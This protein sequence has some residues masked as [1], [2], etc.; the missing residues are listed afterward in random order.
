[1]IKIMLAAAAFG[2]IVGI[3]GCAHKI[4]STPATMTYD[5]S[6][7]DYSKVESMKHASVCK[8]DDSADGDTTIIAA[9]RAA[10]VSKVKHVDNSFEYSRFLWFLI[11]QR[12]C[13]TVYGE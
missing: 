11:G 1:M 6:S 13:V 10:G 2:A 9:A 12:H 8:Y 5:G 4:V 3:S 7:V